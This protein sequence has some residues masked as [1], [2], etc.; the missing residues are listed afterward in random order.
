MGQLYLKEIRRNY[1]AVPVAIEIHKASMAPPSFEGSPAWL[2]LFG[3]ICFN[4]SEKLF[5]LVIKRAPVDSDSDSDTGRGI[6]IGI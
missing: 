2:F 1:V 3:I 4:S 5:K 6:G